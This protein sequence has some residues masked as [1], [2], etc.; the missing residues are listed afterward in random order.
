VHLR[1]TVKRIKASRDDDVSLF[2]SEM[3]VRLTANL[4]FDSVLDSKL[5]ISINWLPAAKGVA[6]P[7]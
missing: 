4:K 7:L 6:D 3:C 5:R 1:Y 2:S